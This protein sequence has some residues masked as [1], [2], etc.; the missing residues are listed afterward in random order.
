MIFDPS[1]GK[2]VKKD[3]IGHPNPRK[4]EIP[5]KSTM[6]QVIEKGMKIY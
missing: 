6:E 2:G 3:S 1:V 4:I 5:R